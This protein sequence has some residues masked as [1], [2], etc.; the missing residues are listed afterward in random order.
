MVIVILVLVAAYAAALTGYAVFQRTSLR[1]VDAEVE[2]LLHADSLRE[3]ELVRCRETNHELRVAVASH[4]T[5]LEL[6][7][8]EVDR[9]PSVSA[10]TPSREQVLQL[11]REERTRQLDQYGTNEEL[12]LGF[13]SSVSAYPWLFPY[14]DESAAEVQVSFRE[15]YEDQVRSD[16]QPTWMHLIREEV[17]ELFETDHR[18]DAIDEAIQVAALCVSLVEK[19]IMDERETL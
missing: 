3:L 17:A 2:T 6:L 18:Q 16:G 4:V 11:I 19:L 14:T 13:G 7:L 8:G 15:D 12:A 10:T 9:V 1:E 5:C